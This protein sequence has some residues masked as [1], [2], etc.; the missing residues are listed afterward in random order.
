[1]IRKTFFWIHLGCGLAVGL[2]VLSLCVTGLLLT[3]ERQIEHWLTD[4][5]IEPPS[6]AAEKLALSDLLVLVNETVQ[7]SPRHQLVLDSSPDAPVAIRQG[8][9]T[10]ALLDPYTGEVVTP[11]HQWVRDTFSSITRFH[12][13]FALEDDARPIGKFI[14]GVGNLVFLFLVVSG[15]YL[16]LPRIWRARAWKIRLLFERR[17]RSSQL[18]DY[19]WHHVMGI[20]MAVPLAALIITGSVFSFRWTGDVIYATL[21]VERPER[22]APQARGQGQGQGAGR[23]GGQRQGAERLSGDVAFGSV[24]PPGMLTLEE[25]AEAADRYAPDWQEL[26]ITLPRGIQSELTVLVDRGTGAQPTLRD[27]IT[28]DRTTGAVVDAVTFD[29]LPPDQQIR[30]TIRFLHTGEYFGLIGQTIAGL[31]CLAGIL[32]VW[33]GMALAYRRLILP[34]IVRRRRA[35]SSDDADGRLPGTAQPEAL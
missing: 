19:N 32:M 30:G 25:L 2:V 34:I 17:P 13:W 1:M 3:Y 18:R 6:V 24:T 31:A 23:G 12:R 22:S 27:T 26:A 29:E 16:W 14:I 33:T 4:P 11:D 10:F 5:K 15:L 20:W 28:L 35:S 7:L 9:R 21:G 8:R